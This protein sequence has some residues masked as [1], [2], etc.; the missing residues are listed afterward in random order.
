MSRKR[1][2]ASVAE[3]TSSLESIRSD[4]G[5]LRRHLRNERRRTQRAGTLPDLVCQVALALLHRHQ[6]L[7]L[8]RVWV[9]R[10]T[11]AER[12][13][14]NA[15]VDT[16][17]T[18]YNM[19]SH[20]EKEAAFSAPGETDGSKASRLAEEF[21]KE[22]H[23]HNWVTRVNVECGIPPATATVLE[24]LG[25]RGLGGSSRNDPSTN[26][27][28]RSSLQYLRRWRRRWNITM[29]SIPSLTRVSTQELQTKAWVAHA[30]CPS[31]MCYSLS[32][33]RTCFACPVAQA[34]GKKGGHFLDAVLVPHTGFSLDGGTGNRAMFFVDGPPGQPPAGSCRLEV[35]ELPSCPRS[36]RPHPSAP[37][38]GRDF[39]EGDVQT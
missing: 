5:E 27:K 32:V 21:V 20:S 8:V 19:M 4:L 17:A 7:D 2:Q 26:R 1:C 22:L 35:V 15:W 23:L 33:R 29:S 12:E 24:T 3:I 13:H 31:F 34:S 25:E 37:Q 9:A 6:D 28:H 14:V 18:R 11:G 36:P 38:S 39:R 10:K 16:L 30:F